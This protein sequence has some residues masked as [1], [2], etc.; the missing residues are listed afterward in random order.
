MAQKT[1]YYVPLQE[2][3]EC[4]LLRRPSCEN[5]SP[6]VADVNKNGTIHLAH[7]PS[8]NLSGKCVPG[9]ICLM[10]Y[11]TD[12]KGTKIGPNCTTSKYG[13]RKC[14]FH[15][16]LVLYKHIW[17]AAHPKIGETIASHLL[18]PGTIYTS[19]SE[20]EIIRCQAEVAGV[21]G[22][23]MRVDYLLTHKDNTST[24]VEVKTVVD[25]EDDN[26]SSCLDTGGAIFPFGKR[27]QKYDGNKVVSERA[28]KHVSELTLVSKKI[29]VDTQYPIL[30]TCMLF[31]VVRDDCQYFKPHKEA[32]PTFAAVLHTAKVNGVLLVAHK[33]GWEI[34]NEQILCK[35][36]G[37]IPVLLP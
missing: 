33:V 5:K 1:L 22:T 16:F 4:V 7:V 32:C 18:K 11:A 30:N 36:R 34:H 27:T 19:I 37:E 35:D 20:S 13:K 3:T 24:M 14:E 2:T 8:L 25:C 10:K 12:K 28:I 26:P 9:T 21:A 31:I 23:N 29:K 17:I 15:S 6:Y